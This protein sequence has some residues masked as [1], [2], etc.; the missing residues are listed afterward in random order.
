MSFAP[1]RMTRAP[2]PI[3]F[4]AVALLF[5]PPAAL[6]Q[7]PPAARQAADERIPALLHELGR[8]RTPVTAAISPDGNTV[9]WTFNGA[10]GSELHLT[11]VA[12]AEGARDRI[13]SPDTTGDAA[14][15]APGA[16]TAS[17]PVWSPDGKQLAFLSKCETDG[18][19]KPAQQQNIFVWTLAVNS[20][21]QVS[22][23]HGSISSLEWSPDGSSITF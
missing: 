5:L 2:L 21:K 8:V 15:A 12:S 11:R 22:H 23:L 16:C 7:A 19:F 4:A 1:V 6:A 13:I 10:R 20:M 17:H 14:N 18:T 3:L 9:A